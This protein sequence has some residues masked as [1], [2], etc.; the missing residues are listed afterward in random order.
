MTHVTC[1]SD[2][3]DFIINGLAFSMISLVGIGF[4]YFLYILLRFHYKRNRIASQY[5]I[6]TRGVPIPL[7]N[8]RPDPVPFVHR[9]M[10]YNNDITCE[11][12]PLSEASLSH[13]PLYRRNDSEPEYGP[14]TELIHNTLVNK[15]S[16]TIHPYQSS[17]EVSTET[18]GGIWGEETVEYNRALYNSTAHTTRSA[19]L[20]TIL[21]KSSNTSL[22]SDSS[23]TGQVGSGNIP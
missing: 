8:N 18:P 19:F 11:E 1:V 17:R 9:R 20:S 7:P 3:A 21:S 22:Y 12:G 10:Q 2:T 23:V 13:I 6:L 15:H 4:V 16:N 5:P 14:P